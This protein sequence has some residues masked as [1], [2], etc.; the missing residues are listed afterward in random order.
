MTKFIPPYRKDCWLQVARLLVILTVLLAFGLEPAPSSNLMAIP[1][2][3]FEHNDAPGQE[4][5]NYDCEE[6]SHR[7]LEISDVLP[8][9]SA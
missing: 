1:R 2:W 7:E 9:S 6:D 8:T 4:K 3:A 5:V